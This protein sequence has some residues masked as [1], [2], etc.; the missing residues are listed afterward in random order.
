MNRYL[1]NAHCKKRYL[2][3]AHCMTLRHCGRPGG[4][5]IFPPRFVLGS[6][7]V[8]PVNS[9]LGNSSALYAI[10]FQTIESKHN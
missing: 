8:P 1:L 9:L 6:N 4:Y 3:N 5:S 7:P 10:R 2:L